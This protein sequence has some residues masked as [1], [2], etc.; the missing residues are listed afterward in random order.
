MHRYEPRL[1]AVL[2]IA[3]AL[4]GLT[5][6]AAAQDVPKGRE[7]HIHMKG[8]KSNPLGSNP[9]KVNKVLPNAK[10]LCRG[11]TNQKEDCQGEVAWVLKGPDLP[12]TWYVEVRPKANAPKQCFATTPFTLRDDNPV[13]S[14][15]ID[16]M[17]CDRFDV[18]P[19]DVVL[20][21][22]S[23]KEMGREDPLVVINY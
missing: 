18:W 10:G 23:G 5:S 20:L 2:A 11:A 7:I 16:E 22:G 8:S 17:V 3:L 12:A 1:P 4:A 15:P 9:Y 6:P 14:G 13:S 19:Y 21:D